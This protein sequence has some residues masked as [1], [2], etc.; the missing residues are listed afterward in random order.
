MGLYKNFASVGS[1]TLLSRLLGFVRDMLMASILGTG[2][3]ADAFFAAFRFPNLFRRLFAE[4][5]FNSAFIPLFSGALEQ[6]GEQAAQEL[7]SLIISWLAAVLLVA[8]ILAEIFMPALLQPFVPGF[9][10]DPD[11][12]EL[13]VLLARICFPYLACM[14]LMSA[15]GAMLNSFGRFIAAAF[16]P[17]LLNIVLV[18]LILV[19]VFFSHD[20][21]ELGAV[22]I[23]M[24]TTVGGLAQFALVWWA[25]QTLPIKP[26]FVMP[27]LSPDVRRFWTLAVPA[28]LTGGITQ[29]NI[30]IGTIIASSAASAISYLY[31]ADRLYQLPLGIIGIAVGVVLLPELSRHLKANRHAEATKALDDSLLFSMV[32]SVPAAVALYVMALPIISV[33]FERGNFDNAAAVQTANALVAFSWGL[34]A[35]V[36]IKVFQ[37]PFFAREDTLTPTIFAGISVVVNIAMSLALF[38]SMQHV[39]IALA[40]ATSAWVNAI[41]LAIFLIR[42]KHYQ[43]NLGHAWLYARVVVS[44]LGM[45]FSLWAFDWL[46]NIVLT[47]QSGFWISALGLA[48]SVMVGLLAYAAMIHITHVIRLNELKSRFL[49]R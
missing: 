38:P 22:Y 39:G 16:A 25:A 17:V 44:A 21:Q 27:K 37:P 1:M 15:Y 26:K 46:K 4:G 43:L 48:A 32:L 41:L 13:T 34:P 7:A 19:L 14:S 23:A 6:R 49:S 29:I 3:A 40:T 35:F 24:G 11:K 31:F 9:V 12:F 42:R 8:T 36:A 18:T 28:I 45:G 30:F 10:N 47:D 20:D 33:L 5:A 2:L